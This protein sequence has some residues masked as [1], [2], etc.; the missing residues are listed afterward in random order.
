MPLDLRETSISGIPET[1]TQGG[2]VNKLI[3][4]TGAVA[5]AL[6]IVVAGALAAGTVV[7]KP[8]AFVGTYAGTASYQQNDTTVALTANGT[9]KG[10]LIGAGKITG[11]GVANTAGQP[12]CVPFT[13]TGKV[14]GP[15]G[16]IIFKVN[17]GTS[18][19]G[20]QAAENFTIS[21]KATI[22]KATGKL[23]KRKGLLRMSGTYDKTSGAFTVKFHGSLTK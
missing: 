19:C 2:I 14:T 13:G 11:T 3:L 4:S 7:V 22:L 23:L 15:G 18:G 1:T 12:A 20:D 17:P 10:T 6:A 16:T 5:A 9:G 8:I 21:G